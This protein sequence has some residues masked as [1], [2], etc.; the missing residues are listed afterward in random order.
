MAL[1]GIS[2]LPTKEARQ[3]VKLELAK[4]KRSTVGK[5]YYRINNDYDI[6]RLPTKYVGNEAVD[7]PGPL[8][9]SHPWKPGV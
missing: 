9:E 5:P 2:T 1:N 4:A 3:V 6:N 8:Q 7:N